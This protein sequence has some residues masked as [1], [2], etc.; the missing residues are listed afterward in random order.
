MVSSLSRSKRH[1][2]TAALNGYRTELSDN[3]IS[4]KSNRLRSI[5]HDKISYICN[6]RK[7]E[8]TDCESRQQKLMKDRLSFYDNYEDD[9]DF[10]D[11]KFR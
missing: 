10:N 11:Y 4:N 8:S 3:Y 7:Q 2:L 9:Q 1:E 5:Y 6:E